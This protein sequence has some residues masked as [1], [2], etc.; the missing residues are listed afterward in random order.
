MTNFVI[1]FF[2]WIFSALNKGAR[3]Q[4]QEE[5]VE[6]GEERALVVEEAFAT[7]GIHI[8]REVE[9]RAE[10]LI[11]EN[12]EV[13]PVLEKVT[14]EVG[15]F[16]KDHDH[17]HL[18]N[19]G[20]EFKIVV[21]YFHNIRKHWYG[22]SKRYEKSIGT[23]EKAKKSLD[24]FS[25]SLND[26]KKTLRKESRGLRLS[27]RKKLSLDQEKKAA[28]IKRKTE[29]NLRLSALVTAEITKNEE[30]ITKANEFN[31]KIK[32]VLKSGDQ[33][34]EKLSQ[35][36][37]KWKEMQKHIEEL[38]EFI[39][40]DRNL[41]IMLGANAQSSKH[42]FEEALAASREV[43]HLLS[44]KRTLDRVYNSLLVEEEV[45]FQKEEKE[46]LPLAS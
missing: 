19:L 2:K 25:E 26:E 1:R 11:A 40:H 46:E 36:T 17:H 28:I 9:H 41:A 13:V 8:E 22:I 31:G 3:S 6:R 35:H 14:S 44:E 38:K 16:V 24:T 34:N 33:L 5:H 4:H 42:Y 10:E 12:D 23:L 39:K 7:Q 21:D 45:T 18:D 43:N 29:I 20:A 32:E 30:F 15:E 27:L 37:E